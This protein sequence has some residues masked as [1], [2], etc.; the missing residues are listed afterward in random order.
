MVNR[1][2]QDAMEEIQRQTESGWARVINALAGEGGGVSAQ[3][4]GLGSFAW[5]GKARGSQPHKAAGQSVAVETCQDR[6]PFSCLHHI[7]HSSVFQ[8][9]ALLFPGS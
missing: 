6:V 7:V 8:L 3:L 9:E 2:R 5:R 4:R 1:R